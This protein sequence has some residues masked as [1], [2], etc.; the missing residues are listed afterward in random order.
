[1]SHHS[2]SLDTDPMTLIAYLLLM[3]GLLSA[4]APQPPISSPGHIQHTEKSASKEDIPPIAQ[5][6]PYLP[7]PKPTVPLETYTVVVSGVPVDKLLFALGRDAGLNIDIHPGIKGNLTLNAVNQTLPQLL[8]RIAQ[9]IELRYRLEGNHVIITPDLPYTQIYKISYLN[10]S[11]DSR[12]EM[13]ISTQ[14]ISDTSQIGGGSGGKSGGENNSTTTISTISNHQFW[15][16]LEKNILAILANHSQI[17]LSAQSVIVN[18]ETGILTIHATE[19]QHKAVQHFIDQVL[20]IAQQQVLIEATIV[21]VSLSDRYQA[22]IDWQRLHGDF[23]YIQALSGGNLGSAPFYS[24]EYNNPNSKLGDV[25]ATVRFLEE[26]GNIKVLSSPK[27]IALNNQTAILK[28][29]DN[30]VY[31]TTQ[32]DVNETETR[33][34]ETYTTEINTVPVGLVITIIPQINENGNVNLNIRPTVSRIIRYKTDPNPA[35]AQAGTLNQIPEIQIREMETLLRINDG[36]IAVIGGLMQDITEQDK[37]GIPVLSQLPILGDL[38]SYR[39]DHY[40][41][42]ELVIFLR[43]RILK[44]SHVEGNPVYQHY[45]SPQNQ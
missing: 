27:I 15:A 39:D 24:F 19:K 18:P 1:M 14:I 7:V 23:S 35:L 16:N 21:E 12:S 44:G 5:H 38:F 37:T 4:C 45:L 43:P 10:L 8:E 31:F 34:R 6:T 25:S 26:F 17:A 30:I 28:V 40:E 11:R 22:G 36:E 29:V 9:Q 32:V 41:K 2:H 20:S 13:S 3:I 42:T 33:T